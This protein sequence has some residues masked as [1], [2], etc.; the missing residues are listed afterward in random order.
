[1]PEERQAMADHAHAA[2]QRFTPDAI[3]KQYLQALGKEYTVIMENNMSA[4]LAP[5]LFY[6]KSQ[7]RP[8]DRETL[9]RQRGCVVWL[10]G[11]SGSGKTTII[12]ELETRLHA[13]RH[14]CYT[15][16]GDNLRHGLNSDLG[17]T[18]ADR[19]EN[20]RRAGEVA[21]LFAD[22]GLITLCAFISP[23]RKDREKVRRIVTPERFVE[24]YVNAPLAVCEE[25]DPKGLYKRART[26]EIKDFTGITSPYEAPENP[27]IEI[28]T[29]TENPEESA[30]KIIAY[31]KEH[32]FIQL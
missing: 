3:M 22:A 8:A 1:M 27:D 2:L 31:L 11:L 17:F 21:A 20:I 26:G 24:I 29:E 16:D 18:A 12:R 25:R 4:S 30:E 13:L 6:T 15:L 7:I 23:F 14:L 5:T 28:C 32:E 19:E 9:L 10:T